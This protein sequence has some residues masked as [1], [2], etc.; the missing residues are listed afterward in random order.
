MPLQ[1]GTTFRGRPARCI[2]KGR[3]TLSRPATTTGGAT[4]VWWSVGDAT[5]SSGNSYTPGP[6]VFA[7]ATNNQGTADTTWNKVGAESIQESQ[8]LGGFTSG[9]APQNPSD[10]TIG[11][12]ATSTTLLSYTGAG[13]LVSVGITDTSGGSG[14]PGGNMML[15]IVFDGGSAQTYTLRFSAFS[16]SGLWTTEFLNS[17]PGAVGSGSTSGDRGIIPFGTAFKT[18]CVITLSTPGG[19]QGCLACTVNWAKKLI[20]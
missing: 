8:V 6:L 17:A 3:L 7:I 11:G 10:V 4:L 12:G 18:S 16:P 13:G 1:T 2:T 15:A 20:V 9:Y 19:L 5:F 14:S